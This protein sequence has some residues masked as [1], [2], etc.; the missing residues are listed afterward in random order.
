[1]QPVGELIRRSPHAVLHH[2]LI[3]RRCFQANSSQ[4]AVHHPAWPGVGGSARCSHRRPRKLRRVSSRTAVQPS[5][6]IAI[7]HVTRP[8]KQGSA[9]ES[10]A[11]HAG[12]GQSACGALSYAGQYATPLPQGPGLRKR[13]LLRGSSSLDNRGCSA[14]GLPFASPQQGR[15][16]GICSSCRTC[17][18]W[19]ED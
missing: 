8:K 13:G 3:F 16:R 19:P 1:M 18:S 15:P 4:L 2:C 14:P 7:W 12:P 17:G 6:C 9:A 5:V 10:T 11:V